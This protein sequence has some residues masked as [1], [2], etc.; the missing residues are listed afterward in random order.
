MKRIKKNLNLHVNRY[1]E[2]NEELFGNKANC[3]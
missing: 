1:K 2:T 3:K